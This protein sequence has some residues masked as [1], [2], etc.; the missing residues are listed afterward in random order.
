MSTF[1]A[2]PADVVKKWVVIDG[3]GL[4]VG[5]LATIIAMR[6]RGK[7]KP[8]YTPHVDCGDNII[9]INPIIW[10]WARLATRRLPAGARRHTWYAC[11]A[12]TD[13][14]GTKC[15]RIDS[16]R[17]TG[18]QASPLPC[19]PPCLVCLL[20]SR[21]FCGLALP[22]AGGRTGSS[23]IERVARPSEGSRGLY[24]CELG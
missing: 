8:T 7:H 9:V 20:S 11:T 13:Q 16:V 3:T 24:E 21:L 23:S 5:R 15:P 12:D 4:V 2:K 1:S 19:A 18:T 6:L 22:F 17:L 10:C 14:T